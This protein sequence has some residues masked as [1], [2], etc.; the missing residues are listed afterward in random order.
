MAEH[1]QM[2]VMRAI[3][4][5]LNGNTDADNRVRS[6]KVSEKLAKP[7]LVIN[8][9]TG[10]QRNFHWRKADPTY[11]F[12]IK[13]VAD[14]IETALTIAQQAF[15]LLDDQGE[16]DLQGLS[17]GDDWH[18]LKSMVEGDISQMYPVGTSTVYE[19]GFQLRVVMEEK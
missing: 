13:A 15:E 19:E 5:V 18:I 4:G 14:D 16:Q 3:H 11:L 6:V 2:A 17:G 8:K 9:A 12:D 7:Y 1:S 10:T